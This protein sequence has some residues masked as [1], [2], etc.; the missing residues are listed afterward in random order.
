MNLI[1]PDLVFN[2][3]LKC[4]GY[5]KFRL[6]HH[7]ELFE[8]DKCLVVVYLSPERLIF[9]RLNNKETDKNAG[10]LQFDTGIDRSPY[11]KHPV[12]FLF[13]DRTREEFN[14]R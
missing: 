11:L 14:I 6:E 3:S 2:G 7:E 12:C 9:N 10:F 1:V 13:F 4:S 5:E 8:V